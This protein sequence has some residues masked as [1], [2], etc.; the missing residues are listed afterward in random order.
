V[1][2]AGLDRLREGLPGWALDTLGVLV[3]LAFGLGLW[4]ADRG[5]DSPLR[6]VDA[7]AWARM[8]DHLLEGPD[9]GAWASN[10]VALWLGRPEDLDPHRLPILPRLTAL[11]LEVLPDIG[12]AGHL[13]NHAAHVALGPV[14]YLLGSRWMGRGLALG[15]AVAAVT[16]PAGVMA[17]DRYGIDPLVAFALPLA[18]LAAEVGARRWWLAPLAGVVVGLASCTHLTTI[19]IG[20]PCVLLTLFR[21]APGYRRWLGA[22]A[23]AAGGLLG[24]GLAF[25]DYPVLPWGLLTGSLAEGVA[26]ASEHANE[27]A[28]AASMSSALE[29]VRTG[30]PAAVERAVAFLVA[31]TRPAWVPWSVMLWLPWLG[32]L[33]WGLSR[34]RFDGQASVRLPG[35]SRVGLSRLAPLRG[36]GVGIALAL[37]LVPLL[38]F[39]AAASPTRYS[40][41]Y[42]PLGVLLLFR[43]LAVPVQLVEQA[44]AR[45]APKLLHG[46]LG[47]VVAAAVV[48]GTRTPRLILGPLSMQ[49]D[50]GEVADWR[51]GAVLA[52]HFPPGGGAACL[53]REV[54]AYAGRV[55][56]PHTPGFEYSREDEPV[57]AHLD[58]ECGGEGPVPYVVLSG[59]ADGASDARRRMDA[60]VEA[61]TPLLETVVD[62]RYT[63]KVYAVERPGD[64]SAPRRD[65]PS[66]PE[67]ASP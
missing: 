13:V 34:Q 40:H 1:P 45:W 28:L 12:L 16:Y 58:A 50:T 59:V 66:A 53:R 19:G 49:P 9:A 41:N 55:F 67:P 20:V 65:T 29:I 4:G 23:L 22:V 11:V 63:A 10:A 57:R 15:A 31:T 37:A 7:P 14:V 30:G 36:V 3:S 60:W 25:V 18:L 2:R 51:L 47:L 64:A 56:C 6:P 54:V 21:G 42:Y 39:A 17:A 32:V 35:I 26:P 27:G 44:L 43:G 24:V 52:A 5:A 33:G 8:R 38:A 62:A 46:A 61:N 48:Y